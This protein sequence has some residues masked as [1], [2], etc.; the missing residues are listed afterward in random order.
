LTLDTN[1]QH[2]EIETYEGTLFEWRVRVRSNFSSSKFSDWSDPPSRFEMSPSLSPFQ[3]LKWVGGGGQLR[4]LNPVQI[5]K[6]I[7]R[8]TMRISGLGAFYAFLNGKQVGEN[9]MDPPQSVYS[10]TVYYQ[11]FDVTDMLMEGE[12]QVGV[13]LG[14]YKFGYDDLWCNQTYRGP[15]GCR[16]FILNLTLEHND[17]NNITTTTVGTNDPSDWQARSGPIIYD[18]LFHGETYD[19]RI[20][21]DWNGTS[22]SWHVAQEIIPK[23]TAPTGLEVIGEGDV[24]I[25]RGELKLSIAPPLRFVNEFP[26]VS[27][28]QVSNH[29]YVFDF[30]QNMAGIVRMN[31]KGG[32]LPRGSRI[33][34]QHTEILAVKSKDIHGMCSLCPTCSAC[35][36]TL[37]RCATYFPGEACNVYCTTTTDH[38]LRHEPCYPHQSYTPGFPSHDIGPHNTPY[39]YVGDFNNANQTNVYFTSGDDFGEVYTPFFSAA[40]FRYIQVTFDVDFVPDIS[41][42]KAIQVNS[43]VESINKV[44]LPKISGTTFGTTDILQRIHE[45]TL[46][47]QLS[48]LWS[49]PTDCPQRERRGWMGNYNYSLTHSFNHTHIHIHIHTYIQEMPKPHQF[50][51]WKILIC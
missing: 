29:N 38:P 25:A 46:A 18:H 21:M 39:G 2:V 26:A 10:K 45:M 19:A 6:K 11:T 44:R 32:K 31:L 49:V 17:E 14:N 42:F 47:S 37:A 51:L 22:T 13:L 33:E 36:E 48:N 4:L 35:N 9:Y 12:N 3:H 41:M 1:V 5:Q 15:D 20:D 7:K 43:N 16:A 50:K 34:I 28:T 30:G 27:V 24:A 40:G 8:A 23:A